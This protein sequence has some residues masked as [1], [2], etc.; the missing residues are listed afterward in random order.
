MCWCCAGIGGKVDRADVV[1]VDESGSCEGTKWSDTLT[2]M[3]IADNDT[4][5]DKVELS[6]QSELGRLGHASLVGFQL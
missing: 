5:T 2:D 4:L 6:K 1:A 3:D